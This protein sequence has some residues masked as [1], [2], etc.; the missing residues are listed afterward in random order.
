MILFL[1]VH[2]VVEVTFGHSLG[3]SGVTQFSL[4]FCE[5]QAQASSLAWTSQIKQ[6]NMIWLAMSKGFTLTP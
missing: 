3:Y 2:F 4:Q 6:R 5:A 1:L